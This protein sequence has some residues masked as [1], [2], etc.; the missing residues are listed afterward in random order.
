MKFYYYN[1]GAFQLFT[2][3]NVSISS[4][5]TTHIVTLTYP[6]PLIDTESD[7]KFKS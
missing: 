5:G 4:E 7:V 6:D 3:E 1:L 2:S